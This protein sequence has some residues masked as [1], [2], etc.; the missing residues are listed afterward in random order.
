[1]SQDVIVREA[2]ED[3][4]AAIQHVA[5]TTWHAT[6]DDVIGSSA[7]DDLVDEWYHGD[8]LT[9][10]VESDEVLY[11][12]ASTEDVVGYASAGPSEEGD[13]GTA[14]LYAI[15]VGPDYWGNGIG[16]GLLDDVIERLRADE[17]ETLRMCVLAANDV[18]RSFYESYGFPVIEQNTTMLA[19]E[20][21]DEVVYTGTL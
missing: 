9:G 8:T 20:E 7:V 11:L 3:D 5:R 16:T 15:Y 2:V 13:A 19:G 10:A 12:V 6:Y 4:V 18:G 21:I 17:F 14:Q 1:M